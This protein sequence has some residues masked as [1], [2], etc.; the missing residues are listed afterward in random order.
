M[1]PDQIEVLVHPQSIV[2]SLVRFADGGLLAHL[3]PSDMRGPIGYALNWPERRKLPVDRLDLA[4]LGRLDFARPDPARFPALRLARQVLDIGGLG[5]AVF[6]A[7]KEAALD[8]FLTSRIGFL[9]MAVLVEHV[10]ERLGPEAA[11]YGPDYDLVA[12][13]ALDGEARQ[14]GRVWVEA[15][16]GK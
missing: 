13:T 1:R 16:S 10:L 7:A 9:D 11:G 2:H 15:F 8:A 6:N 12:V 4:A 3:G 14:L 5:G